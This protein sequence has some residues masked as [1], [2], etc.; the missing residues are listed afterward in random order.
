MGRRNTKTSAENMEVCQNFINF[1]TKLNFLHQR[2]L[3][4]RENAST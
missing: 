2:L 1:F 3:V 4:G